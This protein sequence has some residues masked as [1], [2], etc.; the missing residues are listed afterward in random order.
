MLIKNHKGLKPVYFINGRPYVW[1]KECRK[2]QAKGKIFKRRYGHLRTC[3][4]CKKEYFITEKNAR[5]NFGKHFCFDC[6]MVQH[7]IDIWQVR[8]NDYKQ[9]MKNRRKKT[10]KP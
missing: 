7:Q 6:F 4:N 5:R 8:I 1:E 2:N 10:K 3:V 9:I